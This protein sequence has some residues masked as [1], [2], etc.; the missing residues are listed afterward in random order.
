MASNVTIDAQVGDAAAT[1]AAFAAAAHV[2]RFETWVQRVTGV[3]MEPRAALAHYDPATDR[4][5]IHAGGGGSCGRR[6][7]SR[8]SSASRPSRCG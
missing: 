3:P 1:A 2:V 4:Y 7:R 6:R 5:T 8:S